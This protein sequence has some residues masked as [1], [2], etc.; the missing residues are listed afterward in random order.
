MSG[1]LYIVST[2]IGNLS[3]F[4]KRALD[5]LD[6]VDFIFAEDT[7]V[8][9]RLMKHYNIVRPLM[10]YQQHSSMAKKDKILSLLL[11]EK[12][13]AIVS[14]AGTPGI[15]DPGN[16]LIDYILEKDNK[17]TIVPIPGPSAV[18]AALSVCGFRAN[19][20][21]FV[22]FLPKKK[23][24][25]LFDWLKEGRLTFAFYESPKRILK[26]LEVIKDYFGEDIRICICRELTKIHET[27]YRELISEA[28]EKLEKDMIKG[29]IVVVVEL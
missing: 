9:S 15:S 18:T 26:S 1:I 28:I 17:I 23:R 22:G 10:T 25:K 24:N 3:D 19:K 12:N 8:T 11:D 21:V 14:D 5:T 13:V 2:P 27:V 20:F 4:S 6:D 29:E 7:R 16:E